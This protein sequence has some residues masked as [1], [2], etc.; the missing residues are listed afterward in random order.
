MATLHLAMD[1]NFIN[2]SV[3]Q[4]EKYYPGDGV[5]VVH[6]FNPQLKMVKNDE[7][8][9]VLNLLKPENHQKVVDLCEER[10]I[11]KIVIHG[12]LPYMEKV[13]PA[14]KARY[15]VK[16]YWIYW[17]YE[18]YETLAYK[19]NYKVLDDP[20]NPFLLSSYYKPYFIT[21]V[22]RKMMGKV[23]A[24]S[25]RKIMG[26]VDYFCFWNKG[27]YDLFQKYF[28]SETKFR[29]FAYSANEKGQEPTNLFP[30]RERTTKRILI[31]HQASVYGNH[32]T[33]FRKLKEIDAENKYD[34]VC[35]V[36]YGFLSIKNNILATGRKY[37]SEKFVPIK[38]YMSRDKYFEML[39]S[40]DIAVFGQR[41]Q[42]ASGNISQLL[43]N[44]VKVFLRN[45]N[46]LLKFFREKGYIVYSFE[47]DLKDASSL[48]P[49][50]LEQQQHNRDTFMKNRLYYE[51]FMPHVLDD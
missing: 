40:I 10:N 30:L 12:M 43:R 27:D 50:T 38:E 31:N 29:F 9:I 13:L 33:I 44:G 18:L 42:E 19:K 7:H 49:L 11:K 47:D 22:I 34:K 23:K 14:I 20:F 2:D 5:Y 37:F 3:K 41:R 8:L 6:C 46:I 15:D 16:I 21:K 45:D 24:D 1:H 48:S 35:P 32:N 36:S 28:P 25:Y 51:D 17:G 26:M 39:D 4:F